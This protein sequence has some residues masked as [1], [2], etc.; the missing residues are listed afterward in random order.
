MSRGTGWASSL[1]HTRIPYYF[2]D[3]RVYGDII[4]D[5]IIYYIYI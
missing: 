2:N 3:K 4:K 5:N 1:T